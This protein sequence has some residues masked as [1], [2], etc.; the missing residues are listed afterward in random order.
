MLVYDTHVP[1]DKPTIGV[2]KTAEWRAEYEV[3]STLKSSGYEVEVLG[4]GEDILAI[5]ESILSFRPHVVFNFIEELHGER[6][7]DQNVVSF[8]E[9]MLI[10]YTGCN[11]RGLM[12]SRDKG[13]SKKLLSFHGIDVPKFHVFPQKKG[14]SLSY[15]F[16]FPLLVKPI[17]EQASSGISQRSIVTSKKALKER[18]EWV[19]DYLGVDAIAEEYIDG[20]ELY[21]GVMGNH[22]V[23]VF[24]T[25]ELSFGNLSKKSF[26]IATERAKWDEKYMRR[27]KIELGPASSLSEVTQRKIENVCKKTYRILGLSGYARMDLRLDPRGKVFLIEANP[28]PHIGAGEAFAASAKLAGYSYADLIKKIIQLGLNWAPGQ[29][30]VA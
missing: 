24:P 9:T 13:L 15:D 6:I 4:L 2:I 5:R 28:N 8:L 1:P 17:A 11:P 18:V 16:S 14:I 29:L 3:I 25:W 30:Q 27:H 12:L 7:L 21:A 10:P 26:P 20:R 23:E 19:H 22:R